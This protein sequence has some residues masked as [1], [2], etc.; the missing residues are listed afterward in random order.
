[1][2]QRILISMFVVPERATERGGAGPQGV[3]PQG[4]ARVA[5]WGGLCPG[6]EYLRVINGDLLAVEN[7]GNKNCAAT[8]NE[9]NSAVTFV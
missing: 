9:H 1:M 3:V 7:R 8:C 2:W 6:L 4:G 5:E